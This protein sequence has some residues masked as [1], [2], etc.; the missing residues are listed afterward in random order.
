MTVVRRFQSWP[1]AAALSSAGPSLSLSVCNSTRG[2]TSI[3]GSMAGSDFFPGAFCDGIA[4]FII[5]D[6]VDNRFDDAAGKTAGV[7]DT[8]RKN[9]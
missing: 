4:T 8:L 7:A 9:G 5:F 1:S 6:V 3:S 2:P